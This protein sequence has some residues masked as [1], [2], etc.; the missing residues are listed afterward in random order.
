MSKDRRNL[1]F[2]DHL[3]ELRWRILK[4]LFSVIVLS[5]VFFIF[6]ETILLFL[7]RPTAGIDG[8][9]LQALSITSEFM[10][11]IKVSFFCGLFLSVP[12]LVFQVWRFV[13]PAID[14]KN[15]TFFI[16][17]ALFSLVLVL[18]AVSLS[19]FFIVPFCLQ[20]FNSY[21]SVA[22]E[23][24]QNPEIHSYISFI[25]WI[26]LQ[27]II[28]FQLPVVS[29]V[30]IRLGVITTEFLRQFRRPAIVLFFVIS[31]ILTPQDPITQIVFA[32]PLVVLY[33]ISILIGKAIERK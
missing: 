15:D 26:T 6:S 28:T 2:W 3:E 25:G 4:V 12:Y 29:I 32:I 22:L 11:H 5:S 18:A 27:C 30:L 1:P 9:T 8:Y 7:K 14:G 31:A 23:I 16:F 21:S 13:S 17:C 19:Y 24:E 10:A 33:E 20:F